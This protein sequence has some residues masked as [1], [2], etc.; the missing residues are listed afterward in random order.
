MISAQGRSYPVERVYFPI[1]THQPFEQE[2]ATMALRLLAQET[3]SMLIFLP[4]SAEIVRV[5]DILKD[6]V[7]DNILL[8]PLYGA[9]SLAEQQKR[10]N[11]LKKVIEKS[12]LLP[13]L[14]KPV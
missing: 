13:I 12:Y 7:D 1:N 4:G 10:L 6:K 8:F 11:R 14:Q 2:I 5:A 9:L 3:G